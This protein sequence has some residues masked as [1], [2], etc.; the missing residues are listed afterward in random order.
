MGLEGKVCVVTGASSG[1]GRA[2]AID[3]ARHGAI[4]CTVARRRQRLAELIDELGGPGPGHSY[5]VT[6][7]SDQDS[8]EEL[9]AFVDD[10][11]ARCDVLVNNAGMTRHAALDGPDGVDAVVD[12]M[13]TN[14]YGA[15]YCTAELLP[16]LESS[17]PSRVVNVASV[18]GKVAAGAPA[19]CASKFALAGWGEAL[20]Y[21]LGPRGV[22]VST[23]NPGFV[24]TEGFPQKDL[25]THPL[26]RSLLATPEEVAV[27]IRDAIRTG[28]QE[29]VVPRWYYLLTLP[30]HI[31]PPLHR[32]AVRRFVAP[33]AERRR[34]SR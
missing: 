22:T 29:R 21:E 28:R 5:C 25:L 17:A 14:F 32:F 12:L 10:T 30:R 9:A 24:S 1:I 27:A 4:L 31:A 15:V 7:V 23:V 26:G 2:T 16:L 11:Y 3:L 18:A 13:A 6:D 20:S 19:Y 33:A 34:S 8:V